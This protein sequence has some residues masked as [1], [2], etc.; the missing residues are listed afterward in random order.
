MSKHV[1]V[2][3][4]NLV[5]VIRTIDAHYSQ[6]LAVTIQRGLQYQLL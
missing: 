1:Q 5:S 2:Y 6:N 4:F 3:V